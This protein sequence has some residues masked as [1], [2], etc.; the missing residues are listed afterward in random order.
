ME[1]SY[2]FVPG[3]RPDRYGKAV[4]AGADRVILDLEDSV[5]GDHKVAA[6][7]A[8][9]DWLRAGNT[10]HVRINAPNSGCFDDDLDAVAAAAG[11]AGVVIPKCEHP[12]QVDSVAA[13]LPALPVIAMLETALGVWNAGELARVPGLYR[14]A[15]GALDLQADLGIR[16]DRDELL[17]ARSRVV[18]A[19]RVGGLPAPID[20]VTVALD[21]PLRLEAD[22]TR[23]R[24][25]GFGGK[26]CIHPGQ[27]AKV[28]QGF[29]PSAEELAWARAVMVAVR[30]AGRGALRFRG[31]MIDRPVIE[32]AR[33]ILAQHREEGNQ[34]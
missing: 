32:R 10:A 7:A 30:Q 2:L 3:D 11:L 13:R 31:E 9:A 33:G 17:Y 21:D 26:F 23:A 18:L 20:G 28:N 34:R 29:L 19:S 5:A 27:V 22:V 24:D 6:R 25:L 14:F 15:F 8:V 16:H 4:A 12:G 1:R